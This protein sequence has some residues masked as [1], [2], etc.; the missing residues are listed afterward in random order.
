MKLVQLNSTFKFNIYGTNNR[1]DRS[2]TKYDVTVVDFA[3]A[4]SPL[5]FWIGIVDIGK[6]QITVSIEVKLNMT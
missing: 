3:R 6:V 5:H 4:K 1:L 2:E